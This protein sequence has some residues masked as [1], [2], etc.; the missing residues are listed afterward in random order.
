MSGIAAILAAIPTS[1]LVVI[2]VLRRGPDAL[3]RLLAGLVALFSR[4]DARGRRA[5]AILRLLQPGQPKIASDKGS[6]P[7]IRVPPEGAK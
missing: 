5:L 3:L 7:S 4:N 6:K 1:V 2:V